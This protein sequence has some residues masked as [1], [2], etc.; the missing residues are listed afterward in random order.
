RSTLPLPKPTVIRIAVRRGRGYEVGRTE[1][2]L[3][4]RPMTLVVSADVSD[5]VLLRGYDR[6]APV[7]PGSPARISFRA[8]RPGRFGVMLVGRKRQIAELVITP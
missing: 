7:A 8:V 1:R 3:A 6:R 4:G 2:L 5:V